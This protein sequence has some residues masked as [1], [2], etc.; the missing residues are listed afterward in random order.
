VKYRIRVLEVGYT[1]HF[2]ADFSFDG[3]F[4]AGQTMF[5]PFSM[6]LLQGDGKNILIDCGFNLDN[7]KKRATFDITG[8]SNGHTPKEVLA[9]VGLTP[10]MIDAVI[11][12][13][14]HWDHV[15]GA[16]CYPNAT[17]YLQKYEFEQ[18]QKVAKNPNYTALHAMSMDLDDLET[19]KAIQQQ[20]RLILLDGETDQLFAGLSIRVSRFAHSFAQQMVRIDDE[21]GVHII[22]GDVCNRP[23][24]LLGTAEFPFLIPNTKFSVGSSFNAVQDYERIIQWVNGDVDRVVM[25]HDGTRSGRYQKEVSELGL[26]IYEI[27]S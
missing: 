12:T 2:P 20:N 21:N 5:N 17:F 6:T 25:T 22:V 11:L 15:G 27:C 19:L 14:L 13:H 23:E 26:S 10:E 18:W 24:N 1:E 7:P 9:T 16:A 3:Y 4:L 8:S